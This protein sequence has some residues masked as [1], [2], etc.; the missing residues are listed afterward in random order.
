MKTEDAREPVFAIVNEIPTGKVLSYGDV[1]RLSG[2]TGRQVGQIMSSLDGP[3]P[4]NESVK[5]WR[6]VAFDGQM[7][8]AKRNPI[9]E[10]EQRE[11]L[12]R[13]GVLFSEKGNVRMGEFRWKTTE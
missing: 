5:W 8:I 9:L 13:E 11:R 6:V 2:C 10:K 12:E 1:G 3:G 4:V 7:P